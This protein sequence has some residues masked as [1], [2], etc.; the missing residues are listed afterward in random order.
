MSSSFIE[1]PDTD[2]WSA[3]NGRGLASSDEEFLRWGMVQERGA[4]MDEEATVD[5]HGF[6]WKR[7]S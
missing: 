3:V 5:E 7:A 1:R 4:W 6:V 2:G